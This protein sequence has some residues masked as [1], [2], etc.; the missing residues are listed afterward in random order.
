M[1]PGCRKLVRDGSDVCSDCGSAVRPAALCRTC[2]QDFV[3]VTLQADHSAP[4][5]P[6]DSFQ[7]DENTTSSRPS[8]IS[9]RKKTTTNSRKRKTGGHERD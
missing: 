9:R 1:N 6:N 7:S 5:L 8:C 3:K 4:A 2:G